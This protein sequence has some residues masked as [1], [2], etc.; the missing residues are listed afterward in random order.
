[1]LLVVPALVG[2][3]FFVLPSAPLVRTLFFCAFALAL[4][5]PLA[6]SATFIDPA[7]QKIERRIGL[8]FLS[9]R[10]ESHPL[11]D[12]TSIS[13]RDWKTKN[14]YQDSTGN[15]VPTTNKYVELSVQLKSRSRPLVLIVLDDEKVARSRAAELAAILD[16]GQHEPR[17]RVWV[18]Q[19]RLRKKAAKSARRAQST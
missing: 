4:L 17:G 9:L 19:E 1:M 18:S 12:V 15:W 14:S 10:V 6:S 11:S 13:L 2:A 16:L 8:V 5:V 7:T 3:T